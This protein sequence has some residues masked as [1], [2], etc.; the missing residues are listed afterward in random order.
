[1]AD[2]SVLV[3]LQANITDFKAQMQQAERA[4]KGVGD[5]SKKTEVDAKT[6]LGRMVQSAD[7]HREAWDTAGTSLLGFGAATVAGLGMSIKAA[8]DWES[9]WA[10]VTKTLPD[11][12][13]FAAT[14]A[15]LR[16]LARTLPATHD[17]IAA[18]A[19]AAGQLG[20]AA[21]SIVPFTKTMIDLGETTNLSADEAATAIAQMMNVMQTAPE[22]VGRLGAALV[23][24]GN[25]GASTEAD[26]LNMTSYLTGAAALIGATESDVLALANTMTSLGINAER[27]GGV[28]TRTMQDIYVAVQNGGDKLK[29]FAEVAGMSADEFARA[30]EDDPIRAIG[31]FTD[32]LAAAKGRGDNVVGMLEDLGIKGTQ[33]TAVLL[34]MAGAQ[35]MVNENL[36]MGA[37]AWEDN[38]ALVEE[39]GKRY[40]TTAA[41]LAIAKNNIND[42]A[43]EIG[44]T[45]LPVLSDMAEGLADAA[46]F[47]AGLP[48]PIQGAVGGLGAVAGVGALA[49]GAF[50][51]LFPRVIETRRAFQTLKGDM[52]GVASGL[53]KVG[54]AAG[55]AGAFL[56]AAGAVDGLM[57]A[58]GPAPASMEATTAALLGV[59][60]SVRDLDALFAEQSSFDYKVNDMA[61]AMDRLINPGASARFNDFLGEITSWG[62]DEGSAGRD[63]LITQFDSI[64]QSMAML[65]ESGNSE[66]AAEQFDE[67]AEKWEAQGGDVE[68]LVNLLP[69]YRAALTAV[70]NE[71]ALAAESARGQATETAALADNLDA[72]YGSLSG[73]AAYLGMDEEATKALRE[74]TDAFGQ[75]LAEFITPLGTYQAMLD[76]KAAAEEAAAIKSA[77]AAGKGADAWRDFVVDSGFSFDEYMRRL[78]EQVAAQDNWQVNMLRLA[79]RVSQGTLDELRRMG[80]EGAPLVADLVNRSDA[81]LDKFDE[82]TARRSAEATG[83]MALQLTQAAPV[84]A[85]LSGTLGQ[86]VVDEL[87]AKLA[88]G[89][90]TVAD[91]VRFFGLNLAGGIN[92][93][94][95]SLGRP[96]VTIQAPGGP[97]RNT[98][99]F[100]AADG[101]L[102]DYYANGGVR[103]DHVAQ[104]APGGAWRVWAEPETEGEAYIPLAPSKRARSVDIWRETGRRLGINDIETYANG[105]IVQFEDGSTMDASRR[106]AYFSKLG[107]G[108]VV[109]EDGSIVRAG[110]FYGDEVG[111][112]T[113]PRPPSTAPF[114]PP[115][116][117]VADAA[118]EK[119]Y[120]EVSAFL[121]AEAAKQEA[122]AATA[123]G[124]IGAGAAGG[125]WQAI[126]AKVH[127][128][129]PSARKTSDYRPGDPGRHGRGK[130]VDVA[131]PRPGDAAAMLAI[132][133]WAAATMGGNLAELIHTPGINLYQGRPHTYNA[134]T[135]ADHYD[136]VHLAAMAKGG[137]LNPHVRDAGGPLLPGYT[138]NATGGLEDVVPRHVT[139]ARSASS[140]VEVRLTAADLH[141]MAITGRLEIGG[142]GFGRFVDAR[143]D[144]RDAQAGIALRRWQ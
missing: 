88:A 106:D 129:F 70:E 94:L 78:E 4:V 54:R 3:R 26:I 22:D 99:G 69:A 47:F 53:G 93:V 30:F 48:D 83:A 96:K 24:L 38:T 76:E 16:N 42:A 85:Q 142:D 9:A 109:T 58:L 80:P 27:G 87:A 101:A 137:I 121:A 52:P 136:H 29:G 141:G 25:N 23:E 134:A 84:L 20:V 13:D 56:A 100:F 120:D 74:E 75:S 33:D 51:L 57:K 79:G 10:G 49:G 111:G 73:Y 130:A 124:P 90:I 97:N 55:I 36:D 128:Q 119:M 19:E 131:G 64:G 72:A 117:T 110:S 114:G 81:E 125:S 37:K 61:D 41:Q 35:G 126:W 112:W 104:I 62:G 103:E 34:Q 133:R 98:T 118:M 105:G 89:T 8:V 39:A 71:Q 65:V 50:L 46:G 28:M 116:S 45:F 140:R 59:G 77:E 43:I 21:D 40:D 44:E 11:D 123:G 92:P 15:G 7:R 115:I 102:V 108:L 17:E 60:D 86:G 18:V 12:A 144:A 122:A 66:R 2:R 6:S 31:A 135:R 95:T 82:V 67:L 127:A 68:D 14:E 32:G 113:L 91:I 132:N 107:P 1:M 138:L 63:R 139:D 5:Q 143:L